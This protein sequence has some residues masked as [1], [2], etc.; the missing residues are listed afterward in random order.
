M[1]GGLKKYISTRS[2]MLHTP[3]MGEIRH[4]TDEEVKELQKVMLQIIKDVAEVCEKHGICYMAVHLR[5]RKPTSGATAAFRPRKP[6]TG[7]FN[8]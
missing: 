2:V 4:I 3:E 6:L 1:L 7:Y 5:K 8:W